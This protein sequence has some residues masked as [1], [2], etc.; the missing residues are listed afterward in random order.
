MKMI[1]STIVGSEDR[2]ERQTP[3]KTRRYHS[4]LIMRVC[5]V[6]EILWGEGWKGKRKVHMRMEKKKKGILKRET[7]VDGSA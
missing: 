3:Q 7:H 6:K 5:A 4:H 2:T 1:K